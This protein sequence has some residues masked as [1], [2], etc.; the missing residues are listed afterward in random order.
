MQGYDE[1]LR[2]LPREGE[3][4]LA[5]AAAEDPVLVLEQ[6]DV[7]VEPPQHPCRS[8]VVATDRLCDR[9]EQAAPLR[10]RRFVHDRDEIRDLDRLRREERASQV[11]SER[12]D[13]AGTRRERGDDRGPH[14]LGPQT[15]ERVDGHRRDVGA[16]DE[17]ECGRRAGGLFGLIH[18]K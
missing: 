10:A 15:C 17:R 18:G 12:T 16:A 13:P 8:D 14:A 3:H 1:R 4:V 5:V 7:D 9:R 2:E 11:G 6:H